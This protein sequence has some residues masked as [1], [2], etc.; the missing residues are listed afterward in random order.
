MFHHLKYLHVMRVLAILITNLFLLHAQAQEHS[1][2]R[3]WN[4]ALLSS[5][6]NDFARPPVHARNLFHA[7]IAL[8]DAWAVYDE[9]ASTYF[10]NH[11]HRDYYCPF[12]GIAT[13]VD[14][15]AAQEEAMSYAAFRLLSHR[16]N[17]SPGFAKSLKKIS[18][19]MAESEYD[20]SFSSI[21]YTTGSP[22]ALGNYI[23]KKII[24]FGLRDGSNELEKYTNKFYKPV[25]L[26][27]NP[28]L[29]GDA[30]LT[31]PNRW[32]PI[33]LNIF[34]DQGGQVVSD[35]AAKFLN[36]EWG[37]VVPFSLKED[38]LTKY[39]RDSHEYWVYH[40]P[41]APPYIDVQKGEGRSTE[42]LWNFALVSIWSSHLDESDNVL[43][44][45]SP[46]SQGNVLQIPSTFEE[47][48]QFYNLFQGGD[49]GTGYSINPY[50]GLPYSPQIVKRGDYAR[51]LAEFWA[52]GP[53]SLTPPGHW[54]EIL[55]YTNDNPLFEKRFE[56]KGEILDDLEW[57]AK[58]YLVLGGAMH[59]AAITAWGIKGYYD[60][61][62]PISALRAMAGRGQSTDQSLPNFHPAGI[63]LYPGYIEQVKAGDKLD[64]AFGEHRNKIKVRAWRGPTSIP[65]FKTDK[66]GVDW[67]LAE[68]WWPYQRPSFVTPPFAGY[69][70]G[71]STF[72]RT[73]AEVMTLLTG[74][75]YFPGGM[76]EFHARRNEFLIFEEGPSEDIVLQWAKYKDASDQCSLSRIWGGIHP[77]A[78]DIP[79]RK[80]G[81]KLGGEA[82]NH[83]LQ[84][85]EGKIEDEI[86]ETPESV[87]IYP[88]PIYSNSQ[89]S[90]E[91][92]AVIGKATFTLS[93]LTGKIV[94]QNTL[95]SYFDTTF[96][97]P[98]QILSG[99]YILTIKSNT[100]QF[101]RK[102]LFLN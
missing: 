41:G 56:G 82:F 16:F 102:I 79:G 31:D 60:Y 29:R 52:D 34:I 94:Y 8:Y 58:A 71:H 74:N 68:N 70:S 47:Y 99:I 4:E 69:I 95:E 24:D 81:E 26:P 39:T 64:G 21:D 83:S 45:I 67:I 90:V 62:R 5:I 54:F 91:F 36:P 92:D 57:D 53:K 93:D 49:N 43:I 46:S 27:F 30:T 32:Q 13:P 101:S 2:A 78:D 76:S 38:D 23:G 11:T 98:K 89:L 6:Q 40:D 33:A 14:K 28:F 51:V 18:D 61:V 44:D 63:T 17:D 35:G 85:F 84:Y 10:L 88:N 19:L 72:S 48:K 42:Y 3:K 15:K 59:D 96:N 9:T 66:A 37:A 73:A 86:R 55:N 65:D 1:I 20:T 7:S 97:L 22:A 77:P 50:T 80:I 100:F 75:E 87:K 25:N 12:V